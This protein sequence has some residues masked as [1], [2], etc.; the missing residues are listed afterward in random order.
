MQKDRQWLTDQSSSSI[1]QTCIT[2]LNHGHITTVKV[3][4]RDIQVEHKTFATSQ[5]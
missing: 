5:T 3:T 2:G 4:K 1:Y